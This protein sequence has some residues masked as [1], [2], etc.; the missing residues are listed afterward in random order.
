MPVC[1][2]VKHL[3]YV[4]CI[5]RGMANY[6]EKKIAQS[7]TFGNQAQMYSKDLWIKYKQ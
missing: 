3:N 2:N 7:V 6:G 5:E 4:C 1:S